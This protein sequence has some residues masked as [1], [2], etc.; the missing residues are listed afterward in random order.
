LIGPE[1]SHLFGT[2]EFGRDVLSRVLKGGQISLFVGIVS[3]LLGILIGPGLGM[4][5]AY[6][7]G[8]TEAGIMR[9]LDVMMSFPDEVF[10]SW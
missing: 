8:K 10:G 4:I 1:A 5:A 2:D 6:A 7:G 3:I 9:F